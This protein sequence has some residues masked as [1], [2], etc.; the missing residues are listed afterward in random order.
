MCNFWNF[1]FFSMLC[2]SQVLAHRGGF[3]TLL[4]NCCRT[5]WNFTQEL[6]ILL[7]QAVDM[8]KIFPVSQDGFLCISVLPFYLGAELLIDMLIELQNTNSIEVRVFG[9]LFLLYSVNK[10]FCTMQLGVSRN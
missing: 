7:K 5:L 1:G 2:W 4:Q 9:Y 8:Y 6:Q 10:C 3:W